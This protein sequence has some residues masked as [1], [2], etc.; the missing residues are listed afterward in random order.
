MT[1]P[2]NIVRFVEERLNDELD[3]ENAGL[4]AVHAAPAAAAEWRSVKEARARRAALRRLLD[5]HRPIPIVLEWE[6]GDRRA[7]D[8]DPPLVTYGCATCRD[9]HGIPYDA[10]CWT[11]R[12]L[13]WQW[14]E[15]L[16]YLPTWTL[17]AKEHPRADHH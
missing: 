10:P 14:H 7:A 13:A 5:L 1:R 9:E 12:L 15:H 17:P 2:D 3:A 8:D 6:P 11:M 4:A 16:D